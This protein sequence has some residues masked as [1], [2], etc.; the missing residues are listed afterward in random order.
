MLTGMTDEQI[1]VYLVLDEEQRQR[2]GSEHAI[3]QWWR[4]AG[5]DEVAL[6]VAP[7]PVNSLSTELRAAIATADH[8]RIPWRPGPT[9]RPDWPTGMPSVTPYGPESN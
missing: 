8:Q 1:L 4:K 3:L 7:G 6:V 9:W 5:T 2:A